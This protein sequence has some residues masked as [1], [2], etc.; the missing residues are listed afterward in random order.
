MRTFALAAAVAILSAP[1]AKAQDADAVIT[2][3]QAVMSSVGDN[4]QAFVTAFKGD[5]GRPE[6]LALHAQALTM[7]ARLGLIA[8][9][10][11]VVEG[12]DERT[13]VTAAIWS[14]WDGFEGKMGEFLTAATALQVA[15]D[16][17]D[18]GTIARQMQAVGETCK[19]CHDD[20]REK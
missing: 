14:D 17:G 3:R 6:T 16:G 5:A 10:D 20:F 18:R 7:G 13:T 1:Q 4:M 9:Q 2:Y 19:A 12:R 8:F 15:V 11:E